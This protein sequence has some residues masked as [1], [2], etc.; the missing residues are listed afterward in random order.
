M[1]HWVLFGLVQFHDVD[2][3]IDIFLQ[4]VN[5]GVPKPGAQVTRYL[6]FQKNVNFYIPNNI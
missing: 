3:K 5:G 6:N 2:D 1:S 4:A